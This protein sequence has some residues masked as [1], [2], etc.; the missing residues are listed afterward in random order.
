MR[1]LVF[2]KNKSQCREFEAE[3][4]YEVRCGN[5]LHQIYE[6]AKRCQCGEVHLDKKAVAQ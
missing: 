3:P 5:G 2:D 6:T 1:I 4:D